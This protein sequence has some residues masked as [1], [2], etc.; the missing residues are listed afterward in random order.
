MR[1][2]VISFIV[3]LIMILVWVWFHFT[4]IELITSFF[5]E[6]LIN[7]SNY[8]YNDNWDKAEVNLAVYI[9]KWE[10]ARNLWVYFINQK[11]IDQ[12]DKGFKMLNVY[13]NNFNKTMAQAQIEELRVLF[14]V[15]KE[16][17]CLSLENIF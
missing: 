13:I 7:L 1:M 6:D 16:N 3:L 2:V 14:N 12:I 5:W 11:D 17:E 8:I 9:K 4:S 10:N 15:I